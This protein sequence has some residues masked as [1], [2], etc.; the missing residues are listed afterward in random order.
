[1][2]VFFP[3]LPYAPHKATPHFAEICFYSP[4]LYLL[5]DLSHT[6]IN[7]YK[8][9]FVLLHNVYIAY[10]NNELVSLLCS[11]FCYLLHFLEN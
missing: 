1:M 6:L 11:V 3:A 4:F 7:A 2:T 5:H 8:L 9:H 10:E